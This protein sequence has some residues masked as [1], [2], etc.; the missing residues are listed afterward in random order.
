MVKGRFR[1]LNAAFGC[2]FGAAALGCST[3]YAQ[4]ALAPGAGG[5]G[6][7]AGTAGRAATGG[8][9]GTGGSGAT[10]AGGDGSTC[11][12]SLADRLSVTSFTTDVDIRYKR[13]G[14]DWFPED[15]R[16]ALAAGPNGDLQVA[17]LE[18]SG[19]NVHVTPLDANGERRGGDVVLS[20][21][22]VGGLVARADGFM[23][24]TRRDDPGE[25]LRDP[26]SSVSASAAAALLV[27]V[28]AG[29]EIFAAALTGTATIVPDVPDDRVRD[30]APVTL[31]G[32]LAFDGARYGAYFQVHGCEG[33]RYASFY[34]D[35]LVYADDSG[36]ALAGGWD[37]KC[38][39]NHGVRML[40]EPGSF[41][42]LCLSDSAPAAGLNLV[43]ERESLRLAPELSTVGYSAGQFGSLVR[44]ADRDYLVG[45][46]SRGYREDGGMREAEKEARDIAIL[47][48]AADLTP[49]GA[50]RWVV[51]TPGIAEA[52]LHLAPYGDRVLVIWDSIED[53][54]CS[55]TTC[56]GR[57]TGTHLRLMDPGGAFVTQDLPISAPPSTDDEVVVLPNGDLAWA[58][59]P[60]PERDYQRPLP[61]D[62]DGVPVAPARREITVAR[63]RY[64]E[65]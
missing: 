32:R 34:A 12:V 23:L 21:F 41:T 36:A 42:T 54:D 46:L 33:H 9:G 17:W 47:G 65:D 57:Y 35:K 61:I 10:G 24:L 7:E 31:N 2:Y 37:W 18:N 39:I 28:N 50:I 59:V 27:R 43:T 48:L 16:V 20:G 45:W 52:N 40:P 30:C 53:L 5:G 4:T 11:P 1:A 58:F 26:N 38:S 14:Y 55:P 56:F 3:D 62:A 44:L 19:S 63:L 60:D 13:R 49:N 22:E 6:A 29:V 51:E 8:R 64:C 15:E 25:P